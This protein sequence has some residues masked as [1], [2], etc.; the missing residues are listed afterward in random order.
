MRERRRGLPCVEPVAAAAVA[1]DGVVS[2]QLLVN[3][4]SEVG[5][6]VVVLWEEMRVLVL[7]PVDD[8]VIDLTA[9]VVVIH[10]LA[11]PQLDGV[12]G[13]ALGRADGAVVVKLLVELDVLRD[14][15]IHAHRVGVV[16]CTHDM[17]GVLFFS[18]VLYLD[19][20]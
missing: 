8:V 12:G 17:K 4:V 5:R 18:V 9:I 7:Q 3:G 20:G 11:L 13:E 14:E 2:P 1:R 19:G 16:I 10:L 15:L 6:V